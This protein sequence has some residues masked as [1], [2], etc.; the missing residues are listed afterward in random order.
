MWNSRDEEQQAGK[1]MAA[2]RLGRGKGSELKKQDG[3][4]WKGM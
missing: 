3:F 4:V 1:R 2:S